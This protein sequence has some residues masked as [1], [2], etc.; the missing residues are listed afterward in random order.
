[1][2][3]KELVFGH[4]KKVFFENIQKIAKEVQEYN[5]RAHVSQKC[6]SIKE[7]V[8]CLINLATDPV[9]LGIM[10]IE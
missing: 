10:W 5:I 8:I 2:V 6:G 1:L 3:C 7:Q 4:S 9:V